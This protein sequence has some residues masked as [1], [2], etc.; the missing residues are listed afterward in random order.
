VGSTRPHYAAVE[1]VR[2]PSL[3]PGPAF[4]NACSAGGARAITGGSST[5][6]RQVPTGDR[7]VPHPWTAMGRSKRWNP[8]Y[9]AQE[10]SSDAVRRGGK[11]GVECT[12]EAD[13][14]R[15]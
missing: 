3:A 4:T 10:A 6:E 7:Q 1:T 12:C 13:W 9:L 5:N 15:A 8:S 2:D 14:L 11:R